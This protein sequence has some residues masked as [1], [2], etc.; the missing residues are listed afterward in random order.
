M[1]SVPLEIVN[2][3]AVK[4]L[5]SKAVHFAVGRAIFLQET[6]FS[7]VGSGVLRI[8]K[9]SLLLDKCKSSLGLGFLAPS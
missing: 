1:L 4:A 8:M 7:A 9:G 5:F 2:F 6:R 3:S